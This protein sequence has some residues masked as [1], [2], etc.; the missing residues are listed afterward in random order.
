MEGKNNI[1]QLYVGQWKKDAYCYT[2]VA[3][4]LAAADRLAP[5]PEAVRQERNLG[6]KYPEKEYAVTPV[7][8]HIAPGIYRERVT[9]ERP[10]VSLLGE[11]PT[12]TVIVFGLGAFEE[13]RPGEKR[14]TFRTAAF[15]VDAP[16]FTAKNLTFQN[17][18]GYGH[19]VGQALAAYVDGDR[20]YFE[21]CRFLGSQ[22][23][24]FTAPL[25]EKEAQPGGFK[26]PGEF[27]P[28]VTGRHYYRNCFIQG[29]VDF[30]FG[31]AICYF[32]N[33]T[34]YSKLPEDRGDAAG[35][36]EKA[37]GKIGGE[38]RDGQQPIQKPVYGYV[39]AA[40]TPKDQEFGYVFEGCRL[41]SDCPEGTVYLG[42][43]WRE[44]AK[45][46]FLN[47]EMGKHIH[48]LGW[49]DWNKD[50]NHFYYREYGSYGEGAPD[51]GKEDCFRADFSGQLTAAEA[52]GY[53]KERIFAGWSVSA[54]DKEENKA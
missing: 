46:V 52:A 39:T 10:R 41:I 54:G 32:E 50:H 12:T 5:V 28:R 27:R 24:L 18:A 15:R 48:P 40:S 11:E 45:T 38:V 26:G 8:I 2:S 42:R 36:L 30:I 7:E 6:K 23:T 1:L 14:G 21:N 35:P 19:T 49:K 43:P 25:P 16:D 44:Y 29:D 4:A 3:E 53:T 31:G 20:C 22:D 37:E 34:L 33:C 17:D 13:I 47:C 9:V 51:F